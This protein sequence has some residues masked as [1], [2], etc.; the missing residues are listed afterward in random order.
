MHVKDLSIDLNEAANIRIAFGLKRYP[1]ITFEEP[2]R[3]RFNIFPQRDPFHLSHTDSRI[4]QSL[5]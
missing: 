2:C 5:N 4:L 1:L 3:I